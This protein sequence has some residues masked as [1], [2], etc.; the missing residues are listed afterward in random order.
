MATLNIYFAY[1]G[2]KDN[3]EKNDYFVGFEHMASDTI[4]HSFAGAY[5]LVDWCVI[6]SALKTCDSLEQFFKFYF[7]YRNYKGI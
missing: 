4:T 7:H 2:T 6:S 3:Q 5:I 1:C